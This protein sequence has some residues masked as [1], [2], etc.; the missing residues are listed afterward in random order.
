[1][2]GLDE[3]WRHRLVREQGAQGYDFSHDKIREVAY[4]ALS[5][6]QRRHHHRAV[7]AALQHVHAQDLDA[8][9]GQIASHL[10]RAGHVDAAIAW[11]QRAA[12]AAQKRYAGV[13]V[14]DLLD[15]ALA[16]LCTQPETDVRRAQELA[17]LVALPAALGWV[18]GY[19]SPRLA[20]V[21]RRARELSVALGAELAPT[22]L[23]SFALAAL[24]RSDFSAANDSGEQLRRRG[25][26]TADDV[27]RV[28]ADYV[29]G[30]AAFW[31]GRFESARG[32]FNAAIERYRPEQSRAHILHYGLD[33]KVVC[34]SRL[35]NTLWFLGQPL[36]AVTTRDAALALGDELGH[37]LSRSTSLV[38]AALLALEMG[39]LELL[40]GYAELLVAAHSHDQTKPTLVATEAI[41]GYLEVADG[42]VA[43]GLAR[44]RR[45]LDETRDAEHAPGIYASMLR[46]LLA[47]HVITQDAAAGLAA[48]DEL[49]ALP[50]TRLWESEARRQ[51]AE[52]LL[53]QGSPP[54]S[55]QTELDR[56]L[57]V[58]R[59][60]GARAL[61]LRAALS[62]LRLQ[63][64]SESEAEIREASATVQSLLDG[65]KESP[66]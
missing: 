54:S 25:E 48:A 12:E 57:Q 44:M 42:Q 46:L 7:A 59:R 19:A 38:F 17:I 32:H 23:R 51:R 37:P 11:Y 2:R 49:M 52:F 4:Q 15:R 34:L 53:S 58:A 39:D 21:H 1:M 3:L 55:V 14:I 26:R 24:S 6:A 31:E 45:A 61:E 20:A 40:R 27:L 62:L 50:A 35:A 65:S 5:P 33:P 10:E 56:A 36:A 18:E 60:Q 22:L 13:E 47:A 43:A 64:Q 28:E 8:V 16:L 66:V 41:V 63:G 30:I 29:L 9:S